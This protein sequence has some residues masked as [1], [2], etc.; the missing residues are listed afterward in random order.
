MVAPTASPDDLKLVLEQVIL[1]TIEEWA[2]DQGRTLDDVLGDYLDQAARRV[3]RYRPRLVRTGAV[4]D[5]DGISLVDE[6]ARF[7]TW[8]VETGWPLANLS[9]PKQGITTVDSIDSEI[10]IT[11]TAD[12]SF[13]NGDRWEILIRSRVR[14]AELYRAAYMIANGRFAQPVSAELGAPRIDERYQHDLADRYWSDF[15][16]AVGPR[17]VAV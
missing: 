1:E 10:Q 2:S 11:P 16:A 17:A 6:A 15:M 9:K 7:E 8:D 4:T 5:T 13:D 3:A 12:L 14:E